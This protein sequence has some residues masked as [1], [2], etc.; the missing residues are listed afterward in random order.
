M[1]CELE[2]YKLGKAEGSIR[3][4]LE[5]KLRRIDTEID[6]ATQFADALGKAAEWAPFISEAVSI[7]EAGDLSNAD[8]TVK[9]VEEALAPI[10][11]K[12]KEYTI[13]CVGH[14]HIDMNW[15][16]SWPETANCAH[17]TFYTV[18][19]ILDEFPETK[20][21]Q[22]QV[23]LY[24]A[25]KT[26][27][28]ELWEDIK[29]KIEKGQWE[30]TAST[31]V[32]GEKNCASGESL[33]RHMLYTKKWLAENLG[34][35]PEDVKIDWSPDTFGHCA[36]M[37]S[38]MSKGGVSRYY[39]MRPHKGPRL[40]RWRAK[41]G[42]ELLGFR[43][44]DP[45]SGYNGPI[46]HA[47]WDCFCGFVKET[48]AKDFMYMYGW[49]D[50]GGGPTRGHIR[51]GLE[52]MTY[53]VFP[54]VKFSTTDEFYSAIEAQMDSLDLPVVEGDINYIFEGCYTTQASIKFA[55]R[56][57]ELELPCAETM[58][59]IG[60]AAA[61]MEYP[62]DI[63]EDAWQKTLFNHFH[64]IFPGS[65]VKATCSYAN[66][67]FQDVL[68]ATSSVKNRVLRRLAE[69]I[70]T[71]SIA[72]RFVSDR[73]GDS[74]GGGSGDT[75]VINSRVRVGASVVTNTLNYDSFGATMLS[76]N[77]EAS[78]PI[79]VYNPKPWKRSEVVMAKVWNKKMDPGKTC[80][81]DAEGNRQKAQVIDSG[82]YFQH[83]Y[84]ALVFEARDIPALGYKVFAVDDCPEPLETEDAVKL[85]DLF[86]QD[87]AGFSPSVAPEIVMENKYIRAR[88]SKTT[89]AV[90]SCIDKETGF[91]Y[92]S[93][94]NGIGELEMQTEQGNGMSAW[95]LSHITSRELLEKGTF[96]IVQ[97]GPNLASVRVDF[98]YNSSFISLETSLAKDS[99][100]IDFKVRTRWM[101]VGDPGKG[102]PTLRA[103]FATGFAGGTPVYET[104]FGYQTKE[105][106]FQEVPALKW[107]DLTGESDD[108]EKYGI[109]LLNRSK[110][111]HSCVDDTIALTLLRSS[112]NPD[113]TPD[114]GDHEIEYSVVFRR[115]G[116]CPVCAV[117]LGEDFNNPMSV[118]SV[119]VQTGELPLE[120]SFGELL[121]EEANVSAIKKAECGEGIIVRF[122]D[123]CGKDS[124]AS[125][126][127]GGL[128]A[129]SSAATVDAIE[130]P[131][132]KN[133]AVIKD[134]V[135]SV[136]LA[137]WSNVS[138]WIK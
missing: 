135:V 26:Y 137:A 108:G 127:V 78:E 130:R 107:F 51:Q 27:F 49:G 53:P 60:G 86:R 125:L 131:E 29:K 104:P 3:E 97:N 48:G 118:T 46:N 82:N 96:S 81:I 132:E 40:F 138:V 116:F 115:G 9:R 99:R 44:T 92:C 75:G 14:A 124:V 71:S 134:G 32:E 117:R 55:N 25:V 133:T 64:D 63:F 129:F 85:S 4:A 38:I 105:Q 31:W 18:N 126:K 50:H 91:E 67:S 136:P 52:L 6:F 43:E 1:A 120:K 16:W 11:R 17:D 73:I 24:K 41:D 28:P 123:I 21:S 65:G 128:G 39:R 84:Y 56:K 58:A 76:L 59:L 33:I 110:Y 61:G 37:P 35:A 12:A 109:T 57:S 8:D 72:K 119:P 45:V 20:F 22:S 54:K 74:L 95:S 42:S 62:F 102:I 113:P 10:G 88:V 34:M 89:G 15:M 80:V 101:E 100:K 122:Y 83:D 23:S 47:S 90:V 70:D 111:G 13:H 2:K 121:T 30:V 98:E 69:R 66:G 68:T 103:Y 114:L 5:A 79:M 7:V 87:L 93:D 19:R 94:V 77:G 112:Y 36:Q 106:D